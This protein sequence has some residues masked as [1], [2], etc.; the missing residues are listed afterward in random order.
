MA[1]H[2]R[3][4][5][6]DAIKTALDTLVPATVAT[7]TRERVYSETESTLPS[8]DI[9]QGAEE[10]EQSDINTI[11]RWLLT[12]SIEMTVQSATV[13]LGQTLNEIAKQVHIKMLSTDELGLSHV[14]S[15]DLVSTD[16][17]EQSEEG[18][19]PIAGLEQI[20]S[21]RYRASRLDP[22]VT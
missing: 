7:V 19:Q 12:V 6:M 15:V 17:F 2:H 9:V 8:I 5:I 22:S 16:P 20:W 21:I 11:I 13:Q 1:D 4:Q 18:R 10:A 14:E 3:E